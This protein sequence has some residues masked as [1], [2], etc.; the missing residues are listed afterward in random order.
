VVQGAPLGSCAPS[1]RSVSRAE[2]PPVSASRVR[3]ASCARVASAGR[4]CSRRMVDPLGCAPVVV[5][6][7]IDAIRRRWAGDSLV[8]FPH[9]GGRFPSGVAHPRPPLIALCSPPSQMTDAFQ[10]PDEAT[11]CDLMEH[12][13][14]EHQNKLLVAMKEIAT[15]S[16]ANRWKASAELVRIKCQTPA[17]F[18]QATKAIDMIIIQSLVCS[19]QLTKRI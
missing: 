11:L 13:G 7:R 5:R 2:F 9:S 16:R 4:R 10:P 14:P 8:I 18:D 3:S 15:E 1:E 6:Y 19:N 12:F 17:D